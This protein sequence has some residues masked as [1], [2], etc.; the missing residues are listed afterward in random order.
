MS[1]ESTYTTF[2]FNDTIVVLHQHGHGV[3]QA[4]LIFREPQRMAIHDK[5]LIAFYAY[6]TEAVTLLDDPMHNAVEVFNTIAMQLKTQS[7]VAIKRRIKA[8]A[9]FVGGALIASSLWL[10]GTGNHSSLIVGSTEVTAPA[11]PDTIPSVKPRQTAALQGQ[12]KMTVP[13]ATGNTVSQAA[14]AESN[15]MQNIMKES[16]KSLPDSPSEALQTATAQVIPPTPIKTEATEQS[17]RQKM[18]DI[19]KRSTDRGLFTIQLSTGHERTLYAFLDPTCAVCRS[20]EPA[21]EQLAQHYNVVIFPVSVVNDGGEAVEKIVPVLCEKDQTARAVAWSELF[22]PDAGL[23]VPGKATPPLISSD[24][25]TSAQAVVA[26]NDTGFRTFGF[27]GT[28]TVLTDSG[29]RL[30]TGMLDAPDKIAH[31]LKIT[32]PMSSEQ[33]DRFV[34][35]LSIQE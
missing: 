33:V 31:F 16:H 19:L 20:M 28:P 27:S 4:L 7:K 6:S 11:G 14:Q 34:S 17:A 26:V 23:Q 2:R 29:I 3:P 30:A 1:Q 5:K 35:S 24:C 8:L 13:P 15:N 18:V 9:L 21:I 10:M 22:R 25:S 32:D 12:P